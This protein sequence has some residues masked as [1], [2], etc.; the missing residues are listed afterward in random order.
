MTGRASPVLE[1]HDVCKTYPGEPPVPAIRGVSIT[2][3]AGEMMAVLGPSG[4]GKSTLLHLAAAL[5]RPTSGMVRVAGRAVEALSD[6]RLSGLR[7]YHVGVVFQQFFLLESLT[8]ADNVAHGLLYRGVPTAA[9]RRAAREALDR[10]GLSHR[11]G[12]RA[13]KLSGGERQR[14][15][16][17]RAIVGNPAIVLADEPTGNLDSAT[18]TAVAELLGELN[19]QGITIVI[20]THDAGVAAVCRRRVELRDGRI[21]TDISEADP[22][23]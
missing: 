19:N 14:V 21:I 9:R 2:V 18:G 23:G 16:I 8:A 13:G 12:H 7:A 10:V 20:I 17:A 1:L 6:R 11:L 3:T 22:H 15:A 4:S 5:D